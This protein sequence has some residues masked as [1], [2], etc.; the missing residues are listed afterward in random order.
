MYIE[1]LDIFIVERRTNIDIAIKSDDS[2]FYI[3]SDHGTN[4]KKP[5]Y[6]DAKRI[7]FP[8][9]FKFGRLALEPLA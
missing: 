5:S 4:V 3:D 1:V 9:I 2:F 7:S 8:P 6:L